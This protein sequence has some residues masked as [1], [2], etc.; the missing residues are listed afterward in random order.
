MNVLP[1]STTVEADELLDKVA[2]MIDL[3][4]YM[5]FHD[6]P[7]LSTFGGHAAAFGGQGWEGW[8]RRLNRW[9]DR[10]V[11]GISTDPCHITPEAHLYSRYSSCL[12]S[13]SRQTTSSVWSTWMGAL[14]GTTRG[15]VYQRSQ[16]P[17]STNIS[18]P[19]GNHTTN[20]REDEPFLKSVSEDLVIKT[21][22]G[23]AG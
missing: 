13:S 3:P 18:R 6:R 10:P 23:G 1:S 12:R 17:P 21:S 20:L 5:R 9:T 2:G 15:K 4:G 16:R 19:M 8:L 14:H 22:T 11:S 7:L